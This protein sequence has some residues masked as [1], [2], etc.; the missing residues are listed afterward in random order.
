MFGPDYAELMNVF[1]LA[2]K[3][4]L[5]AA[6]MKA[7]PAPYPTGGIRRRLDVLKSAAA[8]RCAILQRRPRADCGEP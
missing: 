5:T 1:S 3:R 8:L 2:I 4:G 6:Q 7:M